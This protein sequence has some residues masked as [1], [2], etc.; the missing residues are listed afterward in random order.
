M[1]SKHQLMGWLEKLPDDATVGVGED[2][3]TLE[4]EAENLDPDLIYFEV[5]GAVHFSE[6]DRE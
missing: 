2:G 6:E 5:A 1:I 4:A 3:A